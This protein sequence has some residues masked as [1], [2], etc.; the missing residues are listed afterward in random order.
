MLV[1]SMVA[2]AIFRM[3][4]ETQAYVFTRTMLALTLQRT[5]T[6]RIEERGPGSPVLIDEMRLLWAYGFNGMLPPFSVRVALASPPKTILLHTF[7]RCA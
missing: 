2:L 1:T 3:L 5:L 6:P 7:S 4:P